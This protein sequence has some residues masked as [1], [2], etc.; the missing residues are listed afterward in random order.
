MI[1]IWAFGFLCGSA[2]ATVIITLLYTY[3]P[4]FNDEE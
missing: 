2:V 4:D 3:D 1:T